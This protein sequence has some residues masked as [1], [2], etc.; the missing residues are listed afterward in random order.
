MLVV[1]VVVQ[2]LCFYNKLNFHIGIE[3]FTHVFK[4]VLKKIADF[5]FWFGFTVIWI[6]VAFYLIFCNVG[7]SGCCSTAYLDAPLTPRYHAPP[8]P[9]LNTCALQVQTATRTIF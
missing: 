5:A 4:S 6:T 7:R 2:S 8:R 1:N 9:P 3:L